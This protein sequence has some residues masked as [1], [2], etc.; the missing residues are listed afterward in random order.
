MH[1]AGLPRADG[2][3]LE[4]VQVLWRSRFGLH[5]ASSFVATLLLLNLAQR[6]QGF[7]D[8]VPEVRRHFALDACAFRGRLDSRPSGRHRCAALAQRT[9]TFCACVRANTAA[10]TH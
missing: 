2:L 5:R 8:F 9:D 4:V 6:L 10:C 3:C 7:F 1:A